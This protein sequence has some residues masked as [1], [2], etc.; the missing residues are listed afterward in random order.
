MLIK[1]DYELKGLKVDESV[2][3]FI[4]WIETSLYDIKDQWE[5]EDRDMFRLNTPVTID[6]VF[7]YSSQS[8]LKSR[9]SRNPMAG[10]VRIISCD[11]ER[12][13]EDLKGVI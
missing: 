13:I 12:F 8:T 11:R 3:M 7:I 9:S 5:K 10:W 2:S 4:Y 6:D 1:N